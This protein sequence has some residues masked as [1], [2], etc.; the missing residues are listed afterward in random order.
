MTRRAAACALAL[1]ACLSACTPAAGESAAVDPASDDRSS[2]SSLPT[3]E[4]NGD[5]RQWLLGI[6]S[7]KETITYLYA[8][9]FASE[10]ARLS[11]GSMRIDIYADGLLGS[12]VVLVEGCRRNNV[13]FIVQT[14]APQVNT[15]PDLAVFDLPVAF[16]DIREVRRAIDNPPFMESIN[17]IYAQ[18]GFQL[19]GFA[20][21]TFRVMSSNQKVETLADFQGQTIRTMENPFHMAFWQALGASPSSIA[22]GELHTALQQGYVD[23]QENPYAVFVAN[24]FSKVQNYVMQTNHLP[25]LISLVMNRSEYLSLGEEQREILHQATEIAKA[26]AREQA[27]VWEEEKINEIRDA[28]VE[29]VPLSP[30]V[31]EQMRQAAQP[32]YEQISDKVGRE[33]VESYLSGHTLGLSG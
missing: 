30:E 8:E 2:A 26:Y 14:T 1:I 20:D 12:D 21:Q 28:G 6:D 5:T 19:M 29:V 3:E 23:G 4:K 22:F 9:K 31:L 25:H 18:A 32:I 16:Q 15:M 13:T 33:L 10:V 24:S 11:G 7:P 27:D 17:A